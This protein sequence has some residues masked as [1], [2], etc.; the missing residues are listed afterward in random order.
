[1]AYELIIG[2]R[3]FCAETIEQVINN[4]INLN[5]EWP[6]VGCQEGKIS[7]DAKDLICQLLNK[8][9]TKRLGAKGAI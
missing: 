4:I 6:E 2:A 8:D 3:P 7:S 9:F 1:M 5:I